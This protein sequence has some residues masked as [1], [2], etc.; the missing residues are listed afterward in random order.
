[1]QYLVTDC[2]KNKLQH[3][4]TVWGLSLYFK[5]EKEAGRKLHQLKLDI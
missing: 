3:F 5:L 1:M 4:L 2:D